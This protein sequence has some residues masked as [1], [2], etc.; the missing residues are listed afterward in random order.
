[1]RPERDCCRG[2]RAGAGGDGRLTRG[3]YRQLYPA[4]QACGS[5]ETLFVSH[6]YRAEDQT[7]A[8]HF[9]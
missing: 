8:V 1:V 2:D 5:P 9:Q 6:R 3:T 7:I 4:R